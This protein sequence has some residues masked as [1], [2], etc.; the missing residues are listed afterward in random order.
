VEKRERIVDLRVLVQSLKSASFL[1]AEE[2]V[3][4][5]KPAL[6]AL[7]RPNF[8][9]RNNSADAPQHRILASSNG[10]PGEEKLE[11]TNWSYRL[12]FPHQ[13]PMH[14]PAVLN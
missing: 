7:Q 13:K 5:L 6:V 1:G 2:L 8:V 3:H 14:G 11:L 12:I 9:Y 4:G 10:R